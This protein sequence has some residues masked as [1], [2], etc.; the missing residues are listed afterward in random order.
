MRIGAIDVLR[1]IFVVAA[2]FII[3]QGMESA[4][5]SIWLFLLGMA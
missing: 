5:S 4:V 3:N 1:G 2:L